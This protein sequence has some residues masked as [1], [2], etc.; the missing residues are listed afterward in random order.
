MKSIISK[1]DIKSWILICQA[2]ALPCTAMAVQRV[3]PDTDLVYLGAFGMPSTLGFDARGFGLTFYPNGNGGSGSL[4]ISQG[5]AAGAGFGTAEISIPSPVD[6][7]N[8]TAL[9]RSTLLQPLRQIAN[10]T[11][12]L[13]NFGDVVYLAK[14][15][16]QTSDMLY[17]SAYYYYN[18][19][20][21]DYNS[22]GSS[23]LN[24]SSP[25]TQGPW[26]VGASGVSHLNRTGKYIFEADHSWS[27]TYTGGKYLLTG[28]HREAGGAGGSKGP[29]LYAI[30]PWAAGSTLAAGTKLPDVTLLEYPS[31]ASGLAT[32]FPNYQPN[33]LW[34]DAVWVKS[35]DK[36]AVLF[37]G[38]KANSYCYGEGSAC[39]DP[40][41]ASKGYH[42]YPYAPQLIWYDVSELA[43]VAQGQRTPDS[44]V[45]YSN[46]TPISKT[47]GTGQCSSG[48]GGVAYDASNQKIYL[49]ELAAD[50]DGAP[51]VHVLQVKAAGG[52]SS[53]L[54]P[55]TLHV[56]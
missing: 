2:T 33:D 56:N 11:A 39:G 16:T 36:H 14:Q 7:K 41:D 23:G 45:P 52:S 13:D 48:Y 19:E 21:A 37:A 24:L 22:I 8:A 34:N 18:T 32:N 26:H 49:V 40:C 29:T 35:G 55:T 15:G 17:W 53:L 44:V 47:W 46:W 51:I 43:Q 1:M 9:N 20:Y 12:P 31:G 28:R 6:S 54:P 30:A 10:M 38:H 4:F 5:Q 42:G 25:A 27:D 50:T 3:A